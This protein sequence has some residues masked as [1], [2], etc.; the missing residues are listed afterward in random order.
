MFQPL[1]RAFHTFRLRVRP[2]SDGDASGDFSEADWSQ[3]CLG[4]R[5]YWDGL[6]HDSCPPSSEELLNTASPRFAG[7]MYV[8]EL[9]EE[10]V[11]VRLQGTQLELAWSR[12]LTGGDFFPG[13]SPRFRAA[14]LANLESVIAHPCGHL[15]RST[16]ATSKGRKITSD[17]IFLPLTVRVGRRRRVVGAVFQ[18]G[19]LKAYDE[20]GINHFEMH[21][22]SWLDIGF[23]VPTSG[24]LPLLD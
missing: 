21:R 3:E 2:S 1:L 15:A 23:G 14:G 9:A 17:W 6:R 11:I 16:Y 20:V 8:L 22:L 19:S 4:F 18:H 5:E 7:Y 10:A 24:P 12:D 13:R